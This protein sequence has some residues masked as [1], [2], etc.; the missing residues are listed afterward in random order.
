LPGRH[1]KGARMLIVVG[2]LTALS[3]ALFATKSVTVSW[4]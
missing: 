4:R 1:A 2:V 3:L